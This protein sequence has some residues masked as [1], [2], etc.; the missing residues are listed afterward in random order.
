MTGRPLPPSASVVLPGTGTR[1]VAPS[2]DRNKGYIADLL[3]HVAPEKGAAL[4]LASGTGQHIVTFAQALPHFT[5]QP[6]EIDAARRASIAAYVAEAG[7]PNLQP[8]VEID[9]T[10]P[11]WGDRHKADLIVLVNLLHLI[12]VDEARVV[13]TEAARALQSG[14]RFVVYGP[15]MRAGELTSPGDR[16][17]HADLIAA[18][19]A[20]GYKDDFDTLDMMVAA[21]LEIAEVVEMPANNLALVARAW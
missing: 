19:P 5:W 6:S 4:E 1:L 11:G 20:I 12:R 15:F 8:P 10:A 9:A 7:L 21:G 14:G 3:R 16:A 18:D 2:A 13:I 17:F